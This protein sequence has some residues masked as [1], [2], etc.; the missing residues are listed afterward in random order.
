MAKSTVILPKGFNTLD[1]AFAKAVEKGMND[2]TDDLLRIASL[3]TPVDEGTLEK[4]GTSKI[5]KSGQS[6]KGVVSFSA[7]NRGFNYAKQ[8]NDKT[9][10]LGKKSIVKSGKGVRSKFSKASMKVGTGYLTD[11]AEKCADGYSK[12]INDLVGKSIVIK[13]FSR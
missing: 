13:G 4:S 7:R 11:S 5:V 3:R 10:K 6:I 1:D 9:Y 12:H 2:I 8:M